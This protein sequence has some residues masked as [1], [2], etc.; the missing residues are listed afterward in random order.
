MSDKPHYCES[1]HR[2][3]V[4]DAVLPFQKGREDLF[5]VAWKCPTCANRSLIVSPVGPLGAPSAKTCLHCG[6][7]I[8][9]I[10]QRCVACGTLLSQVLTPEE[11]DAPE[12][13][14][15]EDAKQAIATGTC[16][17]GLTI[18]NFVLRRNRR[19]EEAWDIKSQ[20]LE[21]LGFY[22]SLATLRRLRRPWW[23][24]WI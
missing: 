5:Q 10:E 8:Q 21:H 15:L 1:C 11:Q 2:E 9:R 6:H 19:S 17:R 22:T 24:F 12:A 23:Q 4:C 20:F 14:L 7:E 3:C 16:R 18:V 13:Q